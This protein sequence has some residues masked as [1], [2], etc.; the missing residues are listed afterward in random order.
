MSEQFTFKV[1]VESQI[2]LEQEREPLT[3]VDSLLIIF[4]NCCLVSRGLRS[5]PV[6]YCSLILPYFSHTYLNWVNPYHLL[7]LEACLTKIL[8]LDYTCIYCICLDSEHD[9]SAR[10]DTASARHRSELF[11]TGAQVQWRESPA[12]HPQGF[13]SAFRG[14]QSK[15]LHLPQCN[16]IN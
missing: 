1:F 3:R 2:E 8:C 13:G 4:I 7:I 12:V 10:L 14:K 11:W 16:L 5:L 15:D 9:S 6:Y